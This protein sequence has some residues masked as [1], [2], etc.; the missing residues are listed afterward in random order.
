[1]LAAASALA[2]VRWG[3]LSALTGLDQGES[4]GK[5]E[6]LFHFCAGA[7]VLTLRVLL[8]RTT[9]ILPSVSSVIPG[10]RVLE[11]EISEMFGVN[12]AEGQNKKHL[13]LPDDWPDGLYPM[14]K[15]VVIELDADRLR[16]RVE[17]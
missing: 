16:S 5:I 4:A 15:G 17:A 3:Y 6:V 11:W 7:D 1:V 12:V 9:P 8:D 2:T 10:A 14:R 13:Y